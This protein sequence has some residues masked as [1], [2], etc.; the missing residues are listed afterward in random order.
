MHDVY[1][2]FCFVSLRTA[3]FASVHRKKKLLGLCQTLNIIFNSAAALQKVG[4][5]PPG[6]VPPDMCSPRFSDL[7]GQ[8]PF[9]SMICALA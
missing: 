7:P 1:S 6:K 5:S 8:S 3:T 9:V 4:H 2:Y